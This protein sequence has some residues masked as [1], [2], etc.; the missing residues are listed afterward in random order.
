[1][2][3]FTVSDSLAG[4]LHKPISVLG[5][6][7]PY[8]SLLDFWKIK[9]KK[10]SWKSWIFKLKNS[11]SKL[12]FAGYKGSINQVWNRTKNPVSQNW[13]F[14]IDFSEINYR[15]MGW[16][17]WYAQGICISTKNVFNRLIIYVRVANVVA[18]HNDLLTQWRPIKMS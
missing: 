16:I 6:Q 11:I 1:M 18:D 15:W 3:P 9:F 13:L 7:S 8:P 4:Y 12:F 10:S 17:F 14:Q 5:T 2:K